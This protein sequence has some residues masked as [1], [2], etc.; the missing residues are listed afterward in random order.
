MNTVFTQKELVYHQFSYALKDD[1]LTAW[2][3]LQE[4]DIAEDDK[5]AIAID[6]VGF[7]FNEIK[8]I[9]EDEYTITIEHI[10]VTAPCYVSVYK[11]IDYLILRIKKSTFEALPPNKVVKIDGRDKFPPYLK[12]A[13]ELIFDMEF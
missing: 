1:V 9:S 6:T 3:I 11:G 13:V 8:E 4:A 10:D 12:K 7:Y 5:R 2:S